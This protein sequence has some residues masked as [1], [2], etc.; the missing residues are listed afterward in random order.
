MEESTKP[1]VSK[2]DLDHS[3]AISSSLARNGSGQKASRQSVAEPDEGGYVYAGG[4]K[5]DIEVFG[6]I[7]QAF[8]GQ[9]AIEKVS[10]QELDDTTEPPLRLRARSRRVRPLIIP[11]LATEA[12]EL[13]FAEEQLTEVIPYE[14]QPT[15]VE[16]LPD[17][18]FGELLDD[19]QP[20]KSGL[21]NIGNPSDVISKLERTGYQ[22][23]PFNAIQVSLILNSPTATVRSLL[24][25]GPPGCGKT[26][27]AKCLAKV[28]GA[29]LMVL[30]LHPGTD[31]NRLVE[32]PSPVAVAR[33]MVD[34][35]TSNTN[36]LV[37]L[38]TLSQAFIA[39]QTRPVIL[40]VDEIDKAEEAIDAFFLGP[41]ND[42]TIYLE[43]RPPIVANL[44]NLLV[45]LTKNFYRTLDDALMR[46]VTP[47]TMG[48]LDNTLEK[49]ILR[50][51][52]L[53][54][55]SANL[56]YIAD[57]MR[58][59]EG[60]YK[61]ERPPAPDEILRA[62]RYAVQLLEWGITNFEVVGRT[63][64]PL[65]AKSERDR[66]LFEQFL[67][68]HPEFAD[69]LIDDPRKAS[70]GKI[71]AKLGRIILKG[72]VDD[73]ESEQRKLAFQ[74][75]RVGWQHL[76]NPAQITEKLAKVGYECMPYLA[77]QVGLLANIK[78]DMVRTLLLEGPPGCGKSFLAKSLAKI[79]GAEY[80]V[81]QCY[82]GM[83][84]QHLIEHR[85]EIAIAQ[86][87]AGVRVRREDLI[88]LGILARAFLKSQS[89]PVLLL[90]DEI[91]KVDAHI[92]TFFL[93]PLQEARIWLQSRPPIDAN[94]DN[95]ILVFTKNYERSLNDA[96]MRR[97]HP[98]TMTYLDSTL[99]R[100]IL[101]A[102]CIPRLIDNL[103]YIADLMRSSSSTYEFDRPPAPEELL[104]TAKYIL[105]LLE[106]GYDDYAD[107][108]ANVWRMIA[109]SERDR[110]VLEHMFRHH[111][112]FAYVDPGVDPG[113]LPL[114]SI[115]AR[116][117]RLLLKGI[118]KEEDKED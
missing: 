25:E 90:I 45:I 7:L 34:G 53:P 98:L 55:I 74:V 4:H 70:V 73:P 111:P 56:I 20:T 11:E 95:L 22:C 61:F 104:T 67:R 28:T 84:T 118:I 102:H 39:S 99:E 10:Y 91:D 42:G 33:A 44:D 41:L 48:F 51:H 30:S 108:G 31:P 80:M 54:T 27:M 93:G 82:K 3:Q 100:K 94:L 59:S 85:N 87:S 106:W 12:I 76:G 75:E 23:S 89:Q 21:L 115:H 26:F 63:L 79:A 69:S 103:V 29:E 14:L 68:F 47:V 18:Q 8:W 117:G 81:L 58:K 62:G 57:Q 96:L 72:A 38:G 92:D 105:K 113:G 50:P 46:R 107:I 36:E 77:K 37:H 88:E 32:S 110:A 101:S 5:D 35:S 1:K 116:L 19:Y 112:E 17:G 52:V 86:A 15:S 83:N 2:G 13:I 114:V 78:R 66:I 60:Y 24:L 65:I 16:P 49:K 109:K 97:L 43:S 71:M 6:D 40:L 64:L 9:G